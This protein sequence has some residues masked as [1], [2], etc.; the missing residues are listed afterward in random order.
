MFDDFIE[1][2]YNSD[3]MI[4]AVSYFAIIMFVMGILHYIGVY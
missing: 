4:F 3:S 1:W 2:F